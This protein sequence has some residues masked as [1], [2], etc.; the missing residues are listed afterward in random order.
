MATF[1]LE[2]LSS[3]IR[4][5]LIKGSFYITTCFLLITIMF[6]NSV[7]A[8][9][10]KTARDP[11]K[12]V[13]TE[14]DIKKMK[15]HSMV[16]LLNQIPGVS[17]TETSVSFRGSSVKNILVLLDGRSI[18]NPA[19]SYRAVN[20]GM[21]SINAIEKIE[22][23][24]GTGS[25]LYGDDTSG[26][27]VKI[28]TKKIAKRSHG[29]IEVSYGRFD[30]QKYDLNY[31][32]D[33]G[34]I[35]LGLSA[36]LEK[37]H[38]FR[39]NSNE[40]NKR[41]G[42]KLSYKLD[43]KKNVV[44]SFDYSQFEKGNPGPTYSPSPRARSMEKDWGSTFILPLG[45]VKSTTHYS[46]FD[47][48]YNNP[49]T[50]LDN[51]MESWVLN[52]RLSSPISAGRLGHFNIGTDLEIANVEGN[53]IISQQEEKYAFYATK[54]IRPQKTPLNLRLGV[55]VNFYSDFPTAINPQVQLSYKYDNLDIHLSAS[56]SN[57]IPTFYQ[58]YYETSTLK[59]NPDLGM[60]KAMNYNLSLSYR[61][62]ETLEGSIS[63]FL[64][65]INERITYV[66]EGSIGRYRNIGSATLKGIEISAKWVP[67]DLLNAKCSYIYL[68]AKDE[69]TGKYLPNKPKHRF[70][71][72]LQLQSFKDF[73]L[74]LS[75]IYQSKRFSD[76]DNTKAIRGTYF[77]SDLRADYSVKE[78]IKLFFKI[79][80]LFNS[81]YDTMDGYPVTPRAWMM[82]MEY[83]I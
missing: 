82:G 41:I 66:R 31:Q 18:N 2:K 13:I 9:V 42:T 35:G 39:I 71:L 60:E 54:D 67:Y 45:R 12:I 83:A 4:N 16:D 49:D 64:N 17:A 26:G 38:G 79:T 5:I 63:F 46:A 51:I 10:E 74:G 68:I 62:K 55:R 76:A 11:G 30:S 40:D 29:D 37:E 15:V 72:E 3:K 14:E 47:K 73:S 20:W 32:K 53:K 36:G 27:V 56:R 50:G 7:S 77:R 43:Q 65:D 61:P 58:R 28:T 57:N 52:E 81:D 23:Y 8:Q 48:R 21:V 44:F 6:I 59:P 34:N 22:I 78:N 19:S 80:N 75:T 24:K 70:N 33:L 69:D 1:I 25:V